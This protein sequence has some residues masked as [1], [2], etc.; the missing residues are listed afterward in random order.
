MKKYMNIFNLNKELKNLI[1]KKF[2]IQNKKIKK[3]FK[4]NLILNKKNLFF[5]YKLLFIFLSNKKKC[6]N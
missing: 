4:I 3:Y 6:L 5:Y 1:F 2:L